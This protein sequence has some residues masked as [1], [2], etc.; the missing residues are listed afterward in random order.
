MFILFHM[1]KID[2]NLNNV[3]IKNV[4]TFTKEIPAIGT[5]TILKSHSLIHKHK[6]HPFILRMK[7]RYR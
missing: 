4:I 7:Q 6:I 3:D 5:N 1:H 2:H